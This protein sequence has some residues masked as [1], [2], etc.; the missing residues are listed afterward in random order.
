MR[1]EPL[2][3]CHMNGAT[4]HQK[5]GRYQSLLGPES[6]K[7]FDTL[8]AGGA[9]WAAIDDGGVVGV[10]GL[11]DCGEQV[12][13]WVLFTDLITP[14][15]FVAIY[16]ELARRL[17]VLLEEGKTVLIHVDPAYPEAARLAQ[18][19]GFQKTGMDRFDDGRKMI[20][21]VASA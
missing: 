12:G 20:R 1:I 7:V 4:A 3:P 19:L 2:R 18:K 9:A 8:T 14:G 17:A 16:R 13:V 15:G 5:Q 6:S 21:M 10:G 11:L